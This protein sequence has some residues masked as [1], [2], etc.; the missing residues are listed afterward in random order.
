MIIRITLHPGVFACIAACDV[1]RA[2]CAASKGP[3]R[4]AARRNANTAGWTKHNRIRRCP[5]CAG[6][7]TTTAAPA[8]PTRQAAR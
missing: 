5:T 6:N 4:P 8:A 1:C 3:D 7:P 2:R